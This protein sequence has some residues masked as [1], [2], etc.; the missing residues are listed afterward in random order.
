MKFAGMI[1]RVEAVGNESPAKEVTYFVEYETP[2]EGDGPPSRQVTTVRGK[3]GE[4]NAGDRVSLSV[5]KG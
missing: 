2:G 1:R 5:T 3:A 4:Y